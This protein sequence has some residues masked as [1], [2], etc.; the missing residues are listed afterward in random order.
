MSIDRTKL[1]QV[2]LRLP[3]RL[4]IYPPET[5][6]AFARAFILLFILIIHTLTH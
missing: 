3:V 4:K 5:E 6:R 2:I 1:A